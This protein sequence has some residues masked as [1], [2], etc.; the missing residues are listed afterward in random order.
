MND[1]TPR[2]T[3]GLPVYNGEPFLIETLAS[4]LAQTFADF[5]LVISDNGST[6]RT[7]AICQRYAAKD[8]RIRYI[9]SE[10][11]RGAAWNYNRLVDLATGEYF[12]WAGADDLI[13]PGYLARCVAQ[14]DQSPGT[15]LCFT[16]TVL[17]DEHGHQVEE[18][19]N[20]LHLQAA[21]PH[22]RLRDL[23]RGPGLCNP[24]FGLIRTLVLKTTALIGSY[25]DS[26]R[27]LL[28]QLALRGQFSE[29]PEPLFF[30]RIHPQSSVQANPNKRKRVAWF[31]PALAKQLHLPRSRRVMGFLASVRDAPLASSEKLLCYLELSKRF[32]L[33]PRWVLA[34]LGGVLEQIR[35]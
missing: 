30:R 24:I 9:R 33:H 20:R 22:E 12:K 19:S 3:I 14:L 28:G 29:V 7:E 1:H 32:L 17:I 8:A 31:N 16:R 34:D 27:V 23:L 15:V 26:D 25:A 5:E 10:Q 35:E 21:K 18:Y 2:V 13:A 4:L 11:N 6:D